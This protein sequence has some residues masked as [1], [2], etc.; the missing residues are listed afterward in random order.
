MSGGARHVGRMFADPTRHSFVFAKL[1][2]WHDIQFAGRFV[3]VMDAGFI[4][5]GCGR[6]TTNASG[7]A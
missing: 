7:E 1:R 4:S 5:V 3:A 2:R 6:R